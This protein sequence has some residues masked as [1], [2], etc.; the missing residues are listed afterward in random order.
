MTEF[1]DWTSI[2][3]QEKKETQVSLGVAAFIAPERDTLTK[4]HKRLIWKIKLLA[5]QVG[6]HAIVILFRGGKTSAEHS[7][8][9]GA[10]KVSI[11]EDLSR[12]NHV[13]SVEDLGVIVSGAD[14]NSVLAAMSVSTR[15]KIWIEDFAEDVNFDSGRGRFVARVPAYSG[16]MIKNVALPSPAF[17]IAVSTL[18]GDPI[19]DRSRSGSILFP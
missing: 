4:E 18:F 10:D 1:I 6:K 9:C 16:R 14:K 7:F 12:I 8:Y 2:Y 19:E 5:Q 15:N 13:M 11:L 3:G 17:V